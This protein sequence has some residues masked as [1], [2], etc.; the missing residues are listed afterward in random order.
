MKISVQQTQL[1]EGWWLERLGE[2]RTDIIFAGE[3]HVPTGTFHCRLQH[4]EGGKLTEGRG[5]S[6]DEAIRAAIAEVHRG[7]ETTGPV[8]E[9]ARRPGQ[10]VE[11]FPHA[12]GTAGA[13]GHRADAGW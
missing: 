1:P 13:R 12:R 8:N 2:V 3:Q 7:N 11:R 4:V 6:P 5:P 10:P 9:N